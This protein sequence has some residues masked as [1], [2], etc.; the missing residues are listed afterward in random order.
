VTLDLKPGATYERRLEAR[1][2]DLLGIGDIVPIGAGQADEV[3]V[4]VEVWH[5]A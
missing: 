4:G 1:V 5:L 3:L 2:V